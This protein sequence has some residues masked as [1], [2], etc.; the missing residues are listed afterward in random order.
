M[1]VESLERMMVPM[2]RFERQVVMTRCS[3]SDAQRT[4]WTPFAPK[5]GKVSTQSAPN[6][7]SATK[8]FGMVCLTAVRKT[9][10]RSWVGTSTICAAMVTVTMATSTSLRTISHRIWLPSDRSMS[11]SLTRLSG[12]C[13]RSR[14]PRLWAGSALTAPCKSMHRQFGRS[15]L[16]S[17][18]L[19]ARERNLPS[20][21]GRRSR[22]CLR[23]ACYQLAAAS[24][25]LGKRHAAV[26]YN[27]SY[28]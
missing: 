2:W 10:L 22:M 6:C 1:E 7:R 17:A 12:R 23:A 20:S 15:S 11:S 13:C 5:H 26:V 18:R 28:A 16:V 4:K 8:R 21:L 14:P 9:Q 24:H 19:L 3:C 25:V 27:V